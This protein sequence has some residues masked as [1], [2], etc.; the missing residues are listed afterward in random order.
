MKTKISVRGKQIE[1]Q[2]A[3]HAV[4]ITTDKE[5]KE[6]LRKEVKKFTLEL[7]AA[8][9]AEYQKVFSTE[10]KVS[11]RSMSVEIWGHAY[12]DEFA[13]WIQTFSR[14]G[15]VNKMADKVIYH[16]RLI[17]IGESGHD[18]NR[19]VW[20]ALSPFLSLIAFFLP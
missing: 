10:F 15:F 2:F 19:F 14:I 4:R 20:D 11:N 16:A 18:N 13:Q 3:P 9:K 8:V 5:L 12:A 17:D 1:V 6:L 7:V